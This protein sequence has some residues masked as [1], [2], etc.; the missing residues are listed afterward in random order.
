LPSK[1]IEKV[2]DI[3][4]LPRNVSAYIISG[5]DFALAGEMPKLGKIIL[6]S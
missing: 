1:K 3:D 5:Y 6:P 4:E 2:S